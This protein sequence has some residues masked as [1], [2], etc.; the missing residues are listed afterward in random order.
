VG[1]AKLKDKSQQSQ[2]KNAEREQVAKSKFFHKHHLSFARLV[3]NLPVTRK[4][5]TI[6]PPH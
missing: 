6:L 2:Q 3:V 5:M 1:L 4:S